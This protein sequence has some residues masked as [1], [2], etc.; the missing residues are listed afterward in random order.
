M[1]ISMQTVRSMQRERRSR[2]E[3]TF[4]SNRH[5]CCR[6]PTVCFRVCFV[7]CVDH[8]WVFEVSLGNRI[9]FWRPENVLIIRKWNKMYPALILIPTKV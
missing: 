5:R 2:I 8:R 1:R 6:T 7:R 4:P 9:R 3:C